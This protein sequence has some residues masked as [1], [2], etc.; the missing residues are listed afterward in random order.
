MDT[1]GF[2]AWAAEI[3]TM[4]QGNLERQ[5]REA[6]D[7][8]LDAEQHELVSFLMISAP[9]F[10]ARRLTDALIEQEIFEPL[11]AGATLRREFRRSMSSG[12]SS[13]GSKRIFRDFEKPDE[14]EA[15]VPDHIMEEAE[16]ISRSADQSRRIAAQKEA[17][18]DRDPVRHHIVSSLEPLLN[19][20]EEAMESMIAIA[21]TSFYEETARSAAMKLGNSKIVMGR[22]S[23]AGRVEDMIAVGEAAGSQAVRTIIARNLANSMPES[24][25]PSYRSALEYVSEHHPDEKTRNAADRALGS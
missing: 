1:S 5:V 20:S 16:A 23:R 24:S 18:L 8:L 21:R 7:D 19:T 17:E 9:E 2:V 25:D 4:M 12:V 15:G 13:L 6:I 3:K 11:V 22:I 14:G 10:S